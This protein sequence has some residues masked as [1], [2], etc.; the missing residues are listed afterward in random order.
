MAFA[1]GVH[2]GDTQ[3]DRCG[4][5]VVEQ[6]RISTSL[7]RFANLVESLA[8]DVHG[9]P[10]PQRTRRRH[11]A[12][13]VSAGQMVVFQHDPVTEIAAVIPASTSPHGSPLDHVAWS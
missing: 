5:H 6:Q 11:G 1:M 3:I 13:D 7:Q 8:L 10:R 4:G 2:H 9:T 12:S